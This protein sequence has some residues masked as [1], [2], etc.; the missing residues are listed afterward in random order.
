M[1]DY[2][3]ACLHGTLAALL[4]VALVVLLSLWR[5]GMVPLS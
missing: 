3:R 4:F 2:D 5:F 1:D